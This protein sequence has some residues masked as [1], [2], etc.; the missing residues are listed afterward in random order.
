MSVPAARRLPCYGGND[1]DPHEGE[2][3]D[4]EIIRDE[5]AA[6]STPAALEN[7]APAVLLL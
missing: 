2:D 3:L 1:V 4:R 7:P 6:G 5:D